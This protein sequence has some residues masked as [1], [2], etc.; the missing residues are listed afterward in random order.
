MKDNLPLPQDKK[1]TVTF[2]IETGCLGPDGESHIS[3]FCSLAQEEIESIDADFVHWVLV[4]RSDKSLP[5]MQYRVGNK[6]LTH[7]QAE[8]YLNIFEKKLDEFEGHL[9]DKLAQLIDEYLDH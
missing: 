6:N 5:E 7:K 3:D 9:H 2:R 4:P 8:K 1:L